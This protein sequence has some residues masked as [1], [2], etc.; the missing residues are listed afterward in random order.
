M[1]TLLMLIGA[2]MFFG[3]SLF[4]INALDG[5]TFVISGAIIFGAGLVAK[6]V[7]DAADRADEHT[8][9]ILKAL[10]ENKPEK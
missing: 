10:V 7:G 4:V 6:A 1:K 3:A 2:I 9:A 5:T 8:D